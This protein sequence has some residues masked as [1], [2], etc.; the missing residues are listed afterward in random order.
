MAGASYSSLEEEE[1]GRDQESGCLEGYHTVIY[2]ESTVYP[3]TMTECTV[4]EDTHSW[5]HFYHISSMRL[6]VVYWHQIYTMS[7]LLEYKYTLVC[8]HDTSATIQNKK[9]V[10]W[11]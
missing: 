7:E 9:D 2:L 6:S 1:M 10:N 11:H 8:C 4:L 3:P 5:C